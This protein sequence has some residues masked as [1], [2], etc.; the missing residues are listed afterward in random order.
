MTQDSH[1]SGA[2]AL[3]RELLGLPPQSAFSP[4][5]GHEAWLASLSPGLIADLAPD[6][7]LDP[8]LV[9]SAR[10][11]GRY[12]QALQLQALGWIAEAGVACVA[13][14]GFASAFLYYPT[15][16]TRLLADLD[17]LVREPELPV[18][19]RALREKGFR[20]G[21]SERTVWGF[22]SDASFIPF[23]SPDG[24]CN[25]DLHVKPD[26]Y[27]LPLGL[28]TADVFAQA[29]Q[30]MAGALAVHVPSAAHLVLILIANLAK[31]KFAPHGVRKLLDLARL[32]RHEHGFAWPELMERAD[33]ARLTKAL[34][35]SFALLRLLGTPEEWLHHDLGRGRS[36]AT[37][38]LFQ[39]WCRHEPPSFRQ[40]LEREWLLSAEPG[41]ALRLTMRRLSGL[42][43]PR[44]GVPAGFEN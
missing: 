41:V 38:R 13:M 32:L 21:A 27:P 23:H 40:R 5:P 24:H 28:S 42:V 37:D 16:A 2:L 34:H 30:I 20:F 44:S 39:D 35:T 19:V 26:S 11:L 8:S 33:R 43:R 31:D 4:W 17:L 25:I 1:P 15:P 22:L 9:Q 10:L 14:K 29:R 12:Q 36:S 6:H 18:L 7:P 3:W